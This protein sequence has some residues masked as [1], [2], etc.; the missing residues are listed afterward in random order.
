M[1]EPDERWLK[2]VHSG[3]IPVIDV[4]T[5]PP[6]QLHDWWDSVKPDL[7]ECRVHDKENVWLEDIYAAIRNNQAGLYVGTVDGKYA[8]MMVVTDHFDQ[9][10]PSS[11]WLHVWYC[12]THGNLELL[13]AGLDFLEGVGRQVGAHMITF[14]GDREGFE[15]W[16]SRLGF[17]F[18]EVELRR[19]LTNGR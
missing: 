5:V 18:G 12:N 8:G 4:I 7:D 19:E 2:L 10:D 3:D 15:R 17:K 11:R 6:H 1:S 13:R 9:W 16:G 14:R